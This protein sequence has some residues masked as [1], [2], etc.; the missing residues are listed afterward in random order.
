MAMLQFTISKLLTNSDINTKLALP[1]QILVH[2][3]VMEG[4][5]FLDLQVMDS[6][7]QQWTLRYYTRPGGNRA[8]PVFTVGWLQFVRAKHLQVGDE[9]TF[10]G[11][12]VR[13]DDGELQVQY[14]IQRRE[15]QSV[16]FTKK[17]AAIIYSIGLSSVTENIK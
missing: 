4:N 7:E 1:T 5:H 15:E 2:I 10:D 17:N 9:L 13:A 12:Q 11:Y 14:R 16:L 3:P 8:S 6:K